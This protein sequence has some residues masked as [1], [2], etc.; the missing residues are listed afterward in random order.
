[1]LV[2]ADVWRWR[3]HRLIVFFDCHEARTRRAARWRTRSGRCQI[4]HADARTRARVF[5][6]RILVAL[7][8]KRWLQAAFLARQLCGVVVGGCAADAAMCVMLA[9]SPAPPS[10]SPLPLPPPPPPPPPLSTSLCVAVAV[11]RSAAAAAVARSQKGNVAVLRVAAERRAADAAISDG[12][13]QPPQLLS[14]CSQRRHVGR[15]AAVARVSRKSATSAVSAASVGS[16]CARAP[17]RC[18]LRRRVS[19]GRVVVESTRRRAATAATSRDNWRRLLPMRRFRRRGVP[20]AV[21]SATAARV[22]R[23]LTGRATSARAPSEHASGSKA[24]KRV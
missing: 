15:H 1:M 18:A 9:S 20:S 16:R 2:A 10:P 13:T 4:V 19:R 3:A 22:Y 24:S 23:R 8:F 11:G 17:I 12:Y 21:A 14:T 5:T 6:A 7:S